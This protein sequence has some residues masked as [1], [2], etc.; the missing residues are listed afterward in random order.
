[1]HRELKVPGYGFAVEH[2]LVTSTMDLAK[3]WVASSER[4]DAAALFIAREQTAG[5]GRQG[6]RWS[7]PPGSALMATFVFPCSRPI[8]SLGGYSLAAGVGIVSS[9]S[10]VTN[11]LSLKWP[12]DIIYCNKSEGIPTQE[13]AKK[14]GGILIE[15]IP[16]GSSHVISLGLGLNVQ[17]VPTDLNCEAC[18]L[19]QVTS[20]PITVHDTLTLVAAGLLTAHGS[21]LEGGF[22]DA[23]ERW[24]RLSCFKHGADCSTYLEIDTGNEIV[25]GLFCGVTEI[26]A[27]LVHTHQVIK[28]V[29]SGHIIYWGA[30]HDV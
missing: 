20:H 13:S 2:S 5:R 17:G 21:F 27:L 23:K 30:P 14:V 29:H 25:K 28:E 18:S 10:S 16:K 8:S 15:V 3:E 11:Q 4:C 7:S 9:L 19:A 24:Q 12:N 1:V 22:S 6:R 26:G